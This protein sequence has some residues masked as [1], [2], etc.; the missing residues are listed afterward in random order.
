MTEFR[1]AD[2]IKIFKYVVFATDEAGNNSNSVTTPQFT[3]NF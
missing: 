3:V 1:P 2:S